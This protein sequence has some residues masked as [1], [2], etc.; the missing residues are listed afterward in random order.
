MPNGV[1]VG[2]AHRQ[3]NSVSFGKGKV[4]VILNILGFFFIKKK[5]N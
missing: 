1:R 3:P 4:V 2:F 5:M